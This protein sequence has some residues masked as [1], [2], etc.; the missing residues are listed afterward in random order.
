MYCYVRRNGIKYKV[1][2]YVQVLLQRALHFIE[3]LINLTLPFKNDLVFIK[4]PRMPVIVCN[5]E[6][7]LVSVPVGPTDGDDKDVLA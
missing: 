3:P 6:K 4:I 7:Y 5:L 2:E 1:L